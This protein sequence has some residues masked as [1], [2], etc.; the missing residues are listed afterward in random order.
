MINNQK[1]DYWLIWSN[2]NNG[3]SLGQKFD[4]IIGQ[5]YLRKKIV[6]Y[7]KDEGSNFTRMTIALKIVVIVNLLG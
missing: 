5:I 4:R 3:A 2:I 1:C 6:A 7:V